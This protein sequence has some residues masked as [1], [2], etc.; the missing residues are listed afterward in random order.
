M[1]NRTLI[2]NLLQPGKNV[3]LEFFDENGK[4]IIY[5]TL[6]WSFEEERLCVLAPPNDHILKNA[7]SGS[8]IMLICRNDGEAH[9][10]VLTT[11]LI[12]TEVEQ[13]LL[14]INK[15]ADLEFTIG[16]HFFRC[17]VNLPFH[18]FTKK[19]KCPGEIANLSANG[20]Y[21]I[22]DPGVNIEPGSTLTCQI[23]L[24][25]TTA[26][27]LFVAKVTRITR[28]ENFQGVGLSFQQLD[29]NIQDKITQYLFQRQRALI[30]LG[31]IRI[32]K[33]E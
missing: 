24:P 21:A 25:N 23:I 14:I 20:L 18:F 6:V 15:P 3:Q 29:K 11:E 19:G 8:K 32:A 4:K 27:L 9:D 12:K 10:Y 33:N 16:R 17:E 2:A 13:P 30:N 28:K 5:R 1:D 26:Q 31:Q 7:A 22:I